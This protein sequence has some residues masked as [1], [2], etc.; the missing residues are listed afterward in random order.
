MHPK[1]DSCLMPLLYLGKLLALILHMVTC[2]PDFF[3][4]KIQVLPIRYPPSRLS[5]ALAQCCI[6][7]TVKHLEG[8][9]SVCFKVNNVSFLAECSNSVQLSLNEKICST[10]AL[11]DNAESQIIASS[12]ISR[13]RSAEQR[14]RH[15]RVKNSAVKL[16]LVLLLSLESLTPW[17][18][19]PD[20]K[21]LY[22]K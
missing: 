15:T 8:E 17:K 14:S 20:S 10:W 5:A 19:S 4:N 21:L 6:D 18:G 22:Q 11:H 16:Q 3:M 9:K 1:A 7:M 13:A 12:F 2:K